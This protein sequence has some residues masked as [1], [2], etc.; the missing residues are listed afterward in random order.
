MQVSFAY[1]LGLKYH[2]LVPCSSWENGQKEKG[3]CDRHGYCKVRL[4]HDKSS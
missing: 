3:T 2:K 4:Q 1:E